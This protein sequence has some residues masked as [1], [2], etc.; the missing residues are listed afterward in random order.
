MPSYV[1]VAEYKSDAAL[2]H[3]AYISKSSYAD[4]YER[5]RSLAKSPD[6]IRVAICKLVYETG[7]PDLVPK[8][9]EIKEMP[10]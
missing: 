8:E 9:P 5:M 3:E 10:F 1:V 6:I 7:H 2:C 4:A